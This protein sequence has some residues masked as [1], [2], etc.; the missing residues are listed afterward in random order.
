MLLHQ[1]SSR[2]LL[3]QIV[4]V[5]VLDAWGRLQ[6]TLV[7]RIVGE[8]WSVSRVFGAAGEHLEKPVYWTHV[9][10]F[11]I[12]YHRVVNYAAGYLVGVGARHDIL[13]VS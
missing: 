12:S 9:S 4:A 8:A 10:L 7:W 2:F 11:L 5:Q 3:A 6:E 13:E 1:R